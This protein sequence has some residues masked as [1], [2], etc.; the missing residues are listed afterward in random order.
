VSLPIHLI[1]K[2]NLIDQW[3]CSDSSYVHD[4]DEVDELEQWMLE[5]ESEL[6]DGEMGDAELVE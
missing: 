5:G 6:V 2:R 4:Y 3:D 1:S